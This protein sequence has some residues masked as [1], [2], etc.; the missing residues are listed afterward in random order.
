MRRKPTS[1][2]PAAAVEANNFEVVPVVPQVIAASITSSHP[3][4]T[5]LLS[6]V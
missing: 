3:R 5:V 4:F 2:G 1:K 6:T